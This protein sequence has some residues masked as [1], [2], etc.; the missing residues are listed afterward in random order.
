MHCTGFD[1]SYCCVLPPYNSIQSQVIKNST[2]KRKFPELL[3]AD[4]AD[5]SVLVDG[6]K[7]FKLDYGHLDNTYSEGSKL[8]YWDVLYDINGDG[9]YDK[10]ENV[11][12]AYFS[13][14]YVYKDLKGTN[15]KGTSADKEK[16]F[17]GVQIPVPRDNGPAGAAVPSP[18]K[19][20]HLHYTGDKGTIVYTKSPVSGQRAY[21]ADQPRHLGCA[22]SATDAIWRSRRF[23]R[24]AVP[25]RI[26][27]S[28]FPGSL[29][30]HG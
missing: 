3:E 5:P 14:L 9:K 1:F 8:K 13:H 30:K 11:A 7:R 2:G 10:G 19:G 15:P 26:G 12:N 16:L 4:A 24:F 27:Y 29:G 21:R 22:G 18:M 23:G 6:K 25:D 17:V 20:G 28:A